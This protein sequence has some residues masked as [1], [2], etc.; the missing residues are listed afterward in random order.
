MLGVDSRRLGP[1]ELA[2]I[3]YVSESQQLPD[4]LSVDGLLDYLRPFYP[5][6]D[7]D[8]C[9]KLQA[10]L[11][12]TATTPLRTLSRGT[13]MKAALLASL[14]YRPELVL[15]DEPFTGL[16]PMVRDELI[17]AL[18]ELSGQ[19]RFT[20]LISSHDIEE[21]ER[22]ADWVGFIDAGRL[23][24]AEPVDS[25]LRRFR[26]IEVTR[27]PRHAVHA[28]REGLASAGNGG[29]D[30]AIRRHRFRFASGPG[31]HCIG[32]SRRRRTRVADV[33][34]GNLRRA[35]AAVV[36]QGGGMRLLAHLVSAD[37]RRHRWVICLW[38][39]VL[40]ASTVVQGVRPA[41]AAEPAT[42]NT[43]A[44]LSGLLTIVRV[45][46]RIL[47]TAQIIQTHPLV[48]SDAFW[49]TRPIPP[50]MLLQ[51]KA[52]VLTIFMVVAPVAAEIV[53]MVSYGVPP[54][55]IV[56]VALDSAL[57]A[58][59]W[60]ALLATAAALTPTFCPLRSAVWRRTGRARTLSRHSD[61]DQLERAVVSAARR[62]SAET[63]G[64]HRCH[65]PGPDAR[66]RV[67]H[68]AHR[69]VQ[70]PTALAIGGDRRAD[71]R[72]RDAVCRGRVAVAA[73]PIERRP[74]GVGNA[75]GL[76][77]HRRSTGGSALDRADRRS[78]G[79]N[80]LAKI[81]RPRSDRRHRA[82]VVRGNRHARS[83]AA[84]RRQPHAEKRLV[85][86]SRAR[87]D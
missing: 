48:G 57:S 10:D 2:R 24:L 12:L 22:L 9:R 49:L 30:A 35:R 37:V 15:L 87:D 69:A 55:Q 56:R 42:A 41:L 27:R 4:W 79:Q 44:L 76:T 51:A 6:W 3:G 45:L 17:R 82:R 73:P 26:L 60:V 54:G 46:L 53:S 38:L 40:V 67:H 29:P 81:L 85:A 83:H 52:I 66:P 16:D 58:A 21:V 62:R 72:G 39:L 75:G 25:L 64:S 77:T 1:R 20:V 61:H 68:H 8:L 14:A 80:C 70:E 34:T 33:P 59:M 7:E 18:L 5:T 36:A 23:A 11:G 32:I 28:G 31:A 71:D 13:R 47:L 74:S 50:L 19:K 43:V 86:F 65:R 84:N 78:T 63:R